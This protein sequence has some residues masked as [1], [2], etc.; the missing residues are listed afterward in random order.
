[1]TVIDAEITILCDDGRVKISIDDS[2]ACVKFVEIILTPSQFTSLLGRL[3]NVDCKAT[4]RGLDKVGM[5]RI[6][7]PLIFETEWTRDRQQ[8]E[9]MAVEKA[10]KGWTPNLYFNSQDSF[11]TKIGENEQVYARTHQFKWVDEEEAAEHN[12]KKE[13]LEQAEK[14]KRAKKRKSKRGS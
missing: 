13:E 9:K 11:F 6:S 1:M 4:I 12:K 5:V 10:D 3:A 14:E 2:A 7:K 8:V